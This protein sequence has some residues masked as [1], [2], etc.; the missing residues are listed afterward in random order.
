M[1]VLNDM[2]ILEVSGGLGD[3]AASPYNGYTFSFIVDNTFSA[4]AV[5]VGLAWWVSD[6]RAITLCAGIGASW[7]SLKLL[8]AVLDDYYINKAIQQNTTY[9]TGEIILS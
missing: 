7:A 5:G 6:Y 3:V 1:K 4:G 9:V 8:C 2:D